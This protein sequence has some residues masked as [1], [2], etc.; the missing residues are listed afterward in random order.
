MKFCRIRSG[1]LI[2]ILNSR[3]TLL[4]NNEHTWQKKGNDLFDVAMGAYDGAEVC[5]LV[6]IFMLH[7]VSK[8]YNKNNLGLYRDD[9]LGVFKNIMVPKQKESKRIFYKFSKI[10]A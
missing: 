8:I 1:I 10:T 3:K 7:N 6:G 9:G 4:F 2:I 5:E